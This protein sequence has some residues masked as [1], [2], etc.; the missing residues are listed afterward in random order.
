MVVCL[1]HS[2]QATVP[3]PPSAHDPLSLKD[4]AYK[5]L[6]GHVLKGTW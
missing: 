2:P 3:V 5:S 1:T 4:A 6:K